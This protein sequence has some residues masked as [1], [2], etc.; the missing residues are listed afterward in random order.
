MSSKKWLL[1]GFVI[2]ASVLYF[3]QDQWFTRDIDDYGFST[4]MELVNLPDGSRIIVHD[5]PV[6]N[7]GDAIRSQVTAYQDYNGRFLVHAIVQWFSGTKGDTF[8]A[9]ANTLMWALMIACFVLLAFGRKRLDVPNVIVAFGVIWLLM[10]NAMK[11]Y[12]GSISGTVNYLWASAGNLLVLLLYDRFQRQEKKVT[13]AACIAAALLAL[14]VGSLQESFSI[15]IAAGLLV[16]ALTHRKR[17]PRAAWIIVVCYAIG[18]PIC[19]LAPSNFVRAGILGQGVRWFVLID[20]LKVPVC[21]L[22]LLAIILSFV[23]RD[24]VASVLKENTVII[25][26]IVVNLVFAIF[27]AYTGAWQLTCISLLSA[28]LLLQMYSRAITKRWPRVVLAC[29]AACCTVAIYTVQLGYRH[30]MWNLE[31]TMFNEARTSQDGIIN[32]GEALEIDRPYKQSRLAPLYRQYLK[33][34]FEGLIINEQ[35]NGPDLLSKFLTRGGNTSH[36]TAFLPDSPEHMANLFD[37]E[38]ATPGGDLATVRMGNFSI[39]RTSTDNV[40]AQDEIKPRQQ[41]TYGGHVYRLYHG[42]P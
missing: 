29:V 25:T 7:L 12:L 10:P 17:L 41:W 28:I 1:A 35:L 15:G 33:N 19:I 14:I 30:K 24:V 27:I 8:I 21:A 5:Q 36:V 18:T 13:T 40:S 42:M 38:E 9:V 23:R 31:Q 2:L 32:M 16:H 3:M 11:M 39:T 26:A 4:I 37:Q 20:L 34:P 6:N 22:T